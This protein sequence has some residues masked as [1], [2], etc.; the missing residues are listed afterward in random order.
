MPVSVRDVLRALGIGFD[1]LP[2]LPHIDPQILRI[3]Q[4]IPQLA[5][6]ELVGQHLA[7]VLH[8]HAQQVVFL[9]RELHLLVAA[10]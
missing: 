7:G 9:G 8:E 1:L 3:G 2:Q 6:Q 4:I 5:E 10:P